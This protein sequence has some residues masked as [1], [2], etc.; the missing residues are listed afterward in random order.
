MELIFNLSFISLYSQVSYPNTIKP[1]KLE[2]APNFDGIL[3]D[4]CWSKSQ[5]I[6]NFTQRELNEGEKATERTE[7]SLVYTN[8]EIF[9]GVWCYQ[10][11]PLKFTA[12]YMKRDFNYWED[13]NFEVLFDTFFDKR[14]GYIFVINPNGARADVQITDEGRGFNIDWNG[15]WD[16]EVIRSD[17][18]WFAEIRIPFSTLKF[19]NEKI[20]KW[21]VNFERNIRYKNE[22][23]F[24][25]GWSRNYDFEHVSHAGILDSFE[26]IVG[27]EIAELKPYALGG[28]ELSN[29]SNGANTKKIGKFGLD[30]NSLILPTLKLNLSL[31][32]DFAQVESDR[33]K[34]NLTR[35]SIFYPEKRDFFLEGKNDIE[36]DLYDD[37][38]L[39]YSRR[40]GL[41]NG[42]AIPILAAGK[43]MGKIGNS[44][45]GL[46]SVQTDSKN[47][48]PTTNYT[49]L[50]FKQDIFN[51]SNIGAILTSKI[52][53]GYY[54]YVYGFNFNYRTSDFLGNNNLLV[55]SAISQSQT[56][57][58]TG[59]RNLSYKLA[60]AYPNDL[61]HFQAAF[62]GIQKDFNPEMGY[63]ER[64]NY[65]FYFTELMF[66][67]RPAFLPFLKRL[68]FKPFEIALFRDDLTNQ[69]Q[70]TYLEFVPLGIVTK[71]EDVFEIVISRNAEAITNEFEIYPNVIIPV[72]EYWFTRY[73]A[74]IETFKGRNFSLY[75]EYNW[76]DFFSGTRQNIYAS[77]YWNINRHLNVSTDYSKNIINL[78]EGSFNTD[79]IGGR[80][81]YSFNPKLITYFVSQWNTSTKEII[82]NFRLHWIPIIGSDLYF[83][84]NQVFNT[85]SKTI[86]LR[87]TL[88]LTK[89]VWRL[90]F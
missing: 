86:D 25:Q 70:S 3:D 19:S 1:L 52:R 64:D 51:Q 76:G 61:L 59:K 50:R 6:S 8:A 57:G 82:M 38:K 83:V 88:F 72:G 4:D 75:S 11:P 69:M 20:Q 56:K 74:S 12:K 67:P 33:L 2:K 68:Y 27:R 39:F 58:N 77:I 28:I 84:I 40:I 80:I 34:I 44:N 73:K 10:S 31:N 81:E 85:S 42:D 32:T 45:I 23:A 9:I 7:V 62:F 14:N 5:R 13:D 63:L 24:W 65:K 53:S 78:K 47:E 60:V 87:K 48:I 35:F 37:A 71:S 89:F 41:E 21:G 55:E 36:F 46:I 49:V 15:I 79:E 29:S 16:A 22:A 30:I 18:G 90:G 54:N 26:N 17:T 66:R 43:I